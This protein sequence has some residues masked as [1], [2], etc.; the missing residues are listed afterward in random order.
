VLW[1]TSRGIRGDRHDIPHAPHTHS[2]GEVTLRGISPDSSMPRH[3]YPEH[4][5]PFPSATMPAWFT[6]T[7]AVAPR[8]VAMECL[9]H[10]CT[11]WTEATQSATVNAASERAAQRSTG[12]TRNNQRARQ[13]W[14]WVLA[15]GTA[16]ISGSDVHSFCCNGFVL[17]LPPSKSYYAPGRQ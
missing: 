13:R 14:S 10:E 7:S 15:H 1:H 6:H 17:Y 2:L 9:Q 8:W 3:L 11:A 12:E 4:R 5:S 16:R